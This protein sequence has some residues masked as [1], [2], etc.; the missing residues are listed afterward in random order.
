[1][2]MKDQKI[3]IV[4]GGVSGLI[5]AIELEL[6]GF[7]PTILEKNAEIGGRVRTDL[8]EHFPMDHGFQVLLSNYPSARHYL[9]FEEL[10][11]VS[12]RPG[13]VIHKGNKTSRFGDPLR[14]SSFTWST[15]F[16]FAGS[17]GD[18]VRVYG[19]REALKKKSI[20]QIFKEEEM[21]TLDYLK[22]FGFSDQIIEH[23]FRPFFGG[24][25]LE[26]DLRTSSRMFEFA[27]KL[28]SEGS[29]LWPKQGIAAIPRQLRS[30]LKQTEVLLKHEVERVS[31]HKVI[32]SNGNTMDFDA[33]IWATP[34]PLPGN[35]KG[36]ASDWNSC[37]N[38]YFKVEH[39]PTDPIIHLVADKDAYLN[40]FHFINDLLPDNDHA[41]VLSTTVVESK[42]Y[43]GETLVDFVQQDLKKYAGIDHAVFLKMYPIPHALPVRT[44]LS[45]E[46]HPDA[47]QLEKGIF[48]CGDFLANPSINAAMNSGKKAAE[49][50]ID[51]LKEMSVS[52]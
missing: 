45:N 21:S 32:L 17:I 22:K 30:R 34:Y 9:D 43:E 35:K 25:F 15:L 52:A 40:N 12:F 47:I 38:I 49:Y 13:A 39:T 33:L 36:G 37:Y 48:N 51:F 4:G 28:F 46:P 27:F 23:F 11:M 14:D 44:Q 20:D 10:D 18:K 19:L 7:A 6:Q 42:G 5:A 50:C 1:M 24:I 16:S 8:Y 26:K 3:I 2:L 41:S 31:D 29:A